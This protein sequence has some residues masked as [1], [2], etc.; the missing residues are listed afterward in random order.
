MDTTDYRG[1]CS[2]K[3]DSAG[4]ARLLPDRNTLG[5]VWRYLAAAPEGVLRENPACLC[6]KIVRWSG[7]PLQLGKLLACLDIFSDV[8]LLQQSRLHKYMQIRLASAGEKADLS[9]SKTMQQLSRWK[10]EENGNL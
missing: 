6:R 8:G 2:G 3:L 7:Q 5:M 9:Q 10:E 4:A 1:L